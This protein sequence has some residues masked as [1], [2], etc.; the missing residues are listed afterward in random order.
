MTIEL[1]MESLS[2]EREGIRDTW[3]VDTC[4]D[5]VGIRMRKYFKLRE[6]KKGDNQS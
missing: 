4:K 2:S 3:R 1:N 6:C 5:R